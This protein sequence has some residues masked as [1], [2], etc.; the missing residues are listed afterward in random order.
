M[1]V[2]LGDLETLLQIVLSSKYT[3]KIYTVMGFI[4]LI[5]KNITFLKLKEKMPK[6]NLVGR[7]LLKGAA[8]QCCAQMA[9]FV[10]RIKD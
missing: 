5:L 1:E 4:W 10:T 6:Q 8:N 7:I 3:S 9:C 2:S